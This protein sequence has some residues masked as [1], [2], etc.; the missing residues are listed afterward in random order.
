MNLMSGGGE[1]KLLDDT[2]LSLAFAEKMDD[3]KLFLFVDVEDKPAEMFSNSAVTEAAVS[4]VGQDN[5]TEPRN[6]AILLLFL[7][8]LIG[9]VWR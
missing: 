5:A 8:K 4:S 1:R 2:D 7:M 6:Q 3:K 9:T